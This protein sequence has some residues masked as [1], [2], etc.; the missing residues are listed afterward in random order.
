M[1]R[2][3]YFSLLSHVYILTTLL[4]SPALCA[5]E[6]DDADDD[7]KHEPSKERVQALADISHSRCVITATKP[8]NRLKIAQ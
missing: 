1:H 5:C 2:L 3:Q 4:Y 8:M 7:K 6:V